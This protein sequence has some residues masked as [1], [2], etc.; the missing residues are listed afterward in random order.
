MA[1]DS[2]IIYKEWKEALAEYP[3]EERCY[4]YEAIMD[5]A[6]ENI[7][8]SDRFIKGITA[9][10]RQRIDKDQSRYKDTCK[11]RAEAGRLGGLKKQANSSKLKQTEA[12][13]ANATNCLQM[14]A[15]DSKSSKLKQIVANQADYEYDYVYNSFINKADVYSASLDKKVK[16]REECVDM[17]IQLHQVSLESFCM[18]HK[19]SIGQFRDLAIMVLTEWEMEEWK[20]RDRQDALN[21]FKNH[22]LSKISQNL[23]NGQGNNPSSLASRMPQKPGYGLIE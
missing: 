17:Y 3:P 16:S 8:P 10:M 6:F 22:I 19:V 15:N 14:P 5:Y 12:N 4:A 9:L 21:R 7:V 2:M 18:Q 20:P 23:K 13:Q 11:K 1:R